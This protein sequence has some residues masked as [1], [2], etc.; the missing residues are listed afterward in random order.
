VK[1]SLDSGAF[2][3]GRSGGQQVRKLLVREVAA[4]L[5]PSL[6]EDLG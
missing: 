4:V 3:R 5:P 1:A 2:E 6:Q